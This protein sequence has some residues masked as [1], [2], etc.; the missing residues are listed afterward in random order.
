VL[1]AKGPVLRP[2]VLSL[3]D[4]AVRVEVAEAYRHD[5]EARNLQLDAAVTLS[6]ALHHFTAWA[7]YSMN[8]SAET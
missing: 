5:F 8:R 7:K 3:C 2:E 6:I 1:C 4:V